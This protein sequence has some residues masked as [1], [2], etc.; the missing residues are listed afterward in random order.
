MGIDGVV[1]QQCALC[2]KA[3]H[4]ASCPESGVDG[5]CP[6]LPDRR[7][8]EQL[9]EVLPEHPY[10]LDIGFLL[11]LSKGFILD[12]RMEKTLVCVLHRH[13][14]LLPAGGCG[15]ALFL[16]HLALDPLNGMLGIDLHP[17]RYEIE[18]TGPE[19]GQQPVRGNTVEP[20]RE[21]EIILVVECLRILFLATGDLRDHGAPALVQVAELRTDRLAFGYHLGDNVARSGKGFGVLTFRTVQFHRPQFVRKGAVALL[22]G[23]AG[24]GAALGTERQIEV[25]NCL[26][27]DLVFNRLAQGVG[28][29]SLFFNA[30]QYGRLALL[31]FREAEKIVLDG[32]DLDLVEGSGALLTVTADERNGGPFFEESYAVFHLPGGYL[33][34][35]GYVV[36]VEAI[37][38]KP[39]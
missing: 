30:F 38:W 17:D 7:G 1:V 31:Q 19:H 24:T 14:D 2:V 29:L 26:G 25:L 13:P 3:H 35:A 36:D 12:R 15:T 16:I 9:A 4:L 20:L 23:H 37:H 39:L 5:Q 8:E 32:C 28:Q 11:R 18:G 22:A 6:L 21:I 27:V 33:Q 10:R 34:L